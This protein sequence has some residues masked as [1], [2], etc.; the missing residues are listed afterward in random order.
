MPPSAFARLDIVQ[1]AET[2]GLPVEALAFLPNHSENEYL[3]RAAW[4]MPDGLSVQSLL[5]LLETDET[6]ALQIAGRRGNE[7]SLGR[8]PTDEHRWPLMTA[9]DVRYL[10][11][12]TA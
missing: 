1:A 5:K 8:T 11:P 12:T 6:L 4:S 10:P 3:L 2:L 7:V 9:I